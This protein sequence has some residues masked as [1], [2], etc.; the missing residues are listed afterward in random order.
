MYTLFKLT[1]SSIKMFLRNRQ[2]V[3]FTLFMPII[4]MSV[5]GLLG[6]D[7]IPKTNVGIA[8]TAPPT[9][10]T[11]RIIE[12]LKQISAFD[13][14]EDVEFK[15]R[16]ALLDGDRS[17]VLIFPGD[18]IPEDPSQ[19]VVKQTVIALL[20][21]GEMSQ[22]QTALSVVNQFLDK[23]TIALSNAPQLFEVKTEEVNAR[24]LKYF[25]FLLPGVV[26]LAIMQMSVF[27]VA[28]V[29]VDYKEKGILKRLLA[30]P[31]KP[32]H[33][34]TSNVITRLLV[35][36]IQSLILI[37]VGT[38]LFQ[39]QVIGSYWLMLLCIM[40]GAVM[41]LGMGFVISGLAKT[42]EA[43]PAIANL[44]VFPMLFLG[45]TFF[46]TSSM[47]NWLQKVVNFMPLTHLSHSLREIMNRGA[48]F[49]DI[50]TDIFW[51]LGWAV[52]LV[53]LATFTFGLEE[54]RN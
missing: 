29:F 18:L 24:N 49:E 45:G 3:F 38:L 35:A 11:K 40:L 2:A 22:A 44:I 21:V 42:V 23:T 32:Y 1:A 15:E 31:M 13:I 9:E 27:S 50:Q 41:F 33:F 20:N 19:M 26:A 36:V 25:D 48:G 37:G 10:G 6:L 17:I 47:P 43:V 46:P 30:T 28:F 54:K 51:M 12:Q 5:F 8:L 34:V 39:A 4:I 16:Q 14:H 7:N 53:V 52:V